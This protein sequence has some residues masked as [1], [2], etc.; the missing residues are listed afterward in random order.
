MRLQPLLTSDPFH[1][2]CLLE[3][4]VSVHTLHIASEGRGV[5]RPL[6]ATSSPQQDHSGHNDYG[7][8]LVGLGQWT[9]RGCD[10]ISG[11]YP[12]VTIIPSDNP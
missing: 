3:V 4:A 9:G 12:P 10:L 11:Q 1:L 6:P 2:G 5:A 8:G 7:G